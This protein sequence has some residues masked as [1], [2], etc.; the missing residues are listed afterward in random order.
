VNNLSN[1]CGIFKSGLFGEVIKRT[2]IDFDLL[3][4]VVVEN[5]NV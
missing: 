2:G 3:F 1:I 5:C 4:F